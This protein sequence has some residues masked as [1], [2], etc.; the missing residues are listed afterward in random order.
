MIVNRR[1]SVKSV[2][3]SGAAGIGLA[4]KAVLAIAGATTG[5][6]YSGGCKVDCEEDWYICYKIKYYLINWP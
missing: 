6:A 5:A 4:G 3:V 2:G 1:S